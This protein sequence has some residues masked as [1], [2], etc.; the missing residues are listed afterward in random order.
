MQALLILTV[1]NEASFLLEWL[2]HHLTC[3]FTHVLAYSND[4]SDGTD[5]MLDRLA[6]MGHVTHVRNQGPH[7][8]GPQWAALKA[9]D[10][11]PRDE[12]PPTGSCSAMS[13][14]S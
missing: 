5:L 6:A 2:A 13:M 3:G 12:S 10:K 7:D 11:H 9:A 4:C 1:K 8:E 14:N